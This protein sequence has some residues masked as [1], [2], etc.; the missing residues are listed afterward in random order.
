M[1]TPLLLRFLCFLGFVAG[2]CACTVN[3]NLAYF[4]DLATSPEAGQAISNL[5]APVIQAGDQLSITVN[6]LNAES[7]VLLNNGILLPSGSTLASSE[8]TRKAS[9][10]YLVESDGTIKFPILGSV[11][12]AGLS[13][14]QAVAKMTSLIERTV[15]APTV[16]ISFLNFRITV[17]G[18][19]NRPASF[20]VPNEHVSLLEALG[21]AGDMTPY[22]Q[23][24]NVLVI[25]EKAGTRQTA[26][27]DLTSQ[28]VLNSPFFYLQQ[29]DVVY[30]VPD[31]ARSLQASTRAV[32]LPLYIS[33]AS[34]AAILI[35]SLLIRR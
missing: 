3:R 26:R 4:N 17:L 13:R 6:S 2:A 1:T 22:G 9:E 31:K 7:N 20:V 10:G 11:L 24:E 34:V 12:L 29:N 35:S 8:A 18:E 27:L 25:R 5:H 30:V 33:I 32:N 14:D 16:N 23:R 28:A 15:K 21:L 19:V